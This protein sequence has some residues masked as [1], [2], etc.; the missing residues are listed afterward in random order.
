RDMVVQREV[1]CVSATVEAT[2]ATARLVFDGRCGFCTRAVGWLRRLDRQRRV[3]TMPLQTP[4]VPESVGSTEEECLNSLRWR[5]SDGALHSGAAAANAAVSTALGSQ[6]PM[7]LY[8]L[9]SG[10]QERAYNWVAANRHRLPG[11]R[12]HC[13]SNPGTCGE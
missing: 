1:P 12:P 4:G 3:D 13:E 7:R 2:L 10:A 6:L 8:R 9:T 11:T 5:G